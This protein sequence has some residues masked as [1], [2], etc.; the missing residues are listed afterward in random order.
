[1][2][3]DTTTR[4]TWRAWL[5]L[6]VA[7]WACVAP[8]AALTP[9][10]ALGWQETRT[11]DSFANDG[12]SRVAEP[13]QV[14]DPHQGETRCAHERASRVHN[15]LYANADPVSF[16][17]PSGHSVF[18]SVVSAAFSI[19][20]KLLYIAAPTIYAFT[21]AT[22]TLTTTRIYQFFQ[23]VST[24]SWNSASR[25]P[26]L[27]R[28]AELRYPALTGSDKHHI[29]PRYIADAWRSVGIQ[30]PRVWSDIQVSIPNAYH[31]VIHNQIVKAIADYDIRNPAHVDKI[32]RAIEKVLETHPLP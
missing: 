16:S 19:Y 31:Q 32:L 22:N 24:N 23:N 7:C 6:A 8:T 5:L 27:I 10:L 15:Y 17:D 21:K 2:L 1:V 25:L 26:A 3:N 18:S 28:A 20:T 30:V 12:D 13:R 29:L 4:K 14:A 11:S 9:N